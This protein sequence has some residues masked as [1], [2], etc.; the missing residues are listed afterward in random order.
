MLHLLYWFFALFLFLLF[1]IAPF[2][3]IVFAFTFAIVLKIFAFKVKIQVKYFKLDD[4]AE[5][6]KKVKRDNQAIR[7]N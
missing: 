5:K 2:L 6:K 7:K 4:I 3:S 1:S